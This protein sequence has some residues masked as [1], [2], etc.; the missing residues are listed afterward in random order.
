MTTEAAPQEAGTLS[1]TIKHVQPQML[2]PH[3]INEK[4][5]GQE[6]VDQGLKDSISEGGIIEELQVTPDHTVISGHRRRLA[7]IELGLETVPVRVRYDLDTDEKIVWALIE[8]NRLQR[9]KTFEQKLREIMEINERLKKFRAEVANRHGVKDLSKIAEIENLDPEEINTTNPEQLQ[10]FIRDNNNEK[11]KDN[12]SLQIALNHYGISMLHWK[13]ARKALLAIEEFEKSGNMKAAKEIRWTLNNKGMK[14][15]DSVVNRLRGIEVVKKFTR[16][17]VLAKSAI[18]NFEKA[19][20]HLPEDN[21]FI[22]RGNIALGMMRAVRDEIVRAA[23]A[24]EL[25]PSTE[26]IMPDDN[27]TDQQG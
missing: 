18:D 16:P 26:R 15:F 25:E 24:R 14:K 8:A 13:K 11:N 1:E 2:K 19:I 22:A 4:I 21:E 17:S 20:E 6:A 5:Y 23:V 10:E 9:D 3:P 12:S 27:P 7:A